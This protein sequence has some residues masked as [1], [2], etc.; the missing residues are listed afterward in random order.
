VHEGH[1]L[2]ALADLG[3]ADVLASE[4][5]AEID[6]HRRRCRRGTSVPKLTGLASAG[7]W[8]AITRRGRCAY[9][10]GLLVSQRD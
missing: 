2:D 1:E 10:R 7:R 5:V 8:S 9:L 6:H 3:D 4:D